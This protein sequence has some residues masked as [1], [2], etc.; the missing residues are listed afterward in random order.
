MI[1]TLA[2]V[3]ATGAVGRIIVSLLLEREFPARRIKLLASPRSAGKPMEVAG[4]SFDVG[5]KVFAVANCV[6]CHKFGGEGREFGPDLATLEPSKRTAEHILKSI[7]EP[8]H[9]IAEKFQSQV[10][11]LDS[12]KVVTGMVVEETARDCKVMADPL[13]RCE[14]VVVAKADVDERSKS[15]VS[16]MP[17]GLLDKLSQ[18]EILDLM[19]YLLAGADRKHSV[20]AG[21]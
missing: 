12:G 17:K 15:P 19:A 21:Q 5:R 9:E 16:I 3:G 14:P 7:C 6:G 1:D 18:E 4:R 20:Y 10:F 8:S 2:V 13:A 11:V